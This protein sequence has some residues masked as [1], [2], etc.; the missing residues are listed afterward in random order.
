LL[1]SA[2][3]PVD[4]LMRLRDNLAYCITGGRTVFLDVSRGRYF[5][6]PS[7][8]DEAFR[9]SLAIGLDHC[10]PETLSQSLRHAD[11]LVED[12]SVSGAQPNPMLP[13]ARTELPDGGPPASLSLCA[14]ALFAEVTTAIRVRASTFSSLIAHVRSVTGSGREISADMGIVSARI[15]DAFSRTALILPIRDRCVVRSISYLTMAASQDVPAR[16]VIGVALDP[17]CAH[18]WVQAGACV[19]NDRYERVRGFTPILTV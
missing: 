18:C 6:L 12:H 10:S 17:F 2:P 3:L 4:L 5:A 19:L 13:P 7:A 9:A 16:L 8:A 14:R 15:A 11:I 1:A